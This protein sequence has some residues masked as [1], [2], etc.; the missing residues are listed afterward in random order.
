MLNIL[1]KN[2]EYIKIIDNA[3]I[4]LKKNNNINNI[5][6]YI[7]KNKYEINIREPKDVYF[8]YIDYQYIDKN[9]NIKEIN[10]FISSQYKTYLKEMKNINLKQ[11]KNLK[12]EQIKTLIKKTNV[13]Y[14]NFSIKE[15]LINLFIQT[16]YVIK[17]KRKYSKL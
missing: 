16:L 1:S 17:K 6:S 2:I 5:L 14:V 8:P 9:K 12:D 15:I 4:Q 3:I 13:N 10:L 7:K 11:F